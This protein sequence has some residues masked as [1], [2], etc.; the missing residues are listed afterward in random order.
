[1]FHVEQRTLLP[2]AKPCIATRFA[3]LRGSACDLWAVQHHTSI[4]L[5]HRVVLLHFCDFFGNKSNV[6]RTTPLLHAETMIKLHDYNSASFQN[7][8]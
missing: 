3:L 7:Q 1:M 8:V 5:K 6:K 2:L 4:V